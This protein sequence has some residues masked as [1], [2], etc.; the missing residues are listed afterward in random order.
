MKKLTVACLMLCT[1][2]G[3]VFTGCKK[4]DNSDNSGVEMV[5]MNTE[6]EKEEE[7]VIETEKKEPAKSLKGRNLL[8]GEPMEEDK[9]KL[10]P[11]AVMLGNTVD[12]LPQYGIGQA[13]VLYEVPVEGGLTRL[14]AIFQD[15]TNLE[16]VGSVRSCR[17]YFAYYAMEFDAIY[18]HFGQAPY[19]EP[20]LNSGKVSN[21]SGLEGNT[22][23]LAF[24]RDSSRKQP[25]NSF[26]TGKGVVDAIADKGYETDYKDGYA[27]HYV[28]AADGE[29]VELADGMDAK[30]VKPGFSISNP[31]F[32]YNEEDG[33]YYRYQY[34]KEHID[35]ADNSQLA[36]KNIIFQYSSYGKAVSAQGVVDKNGYLD[37]TTTGEGK[38]M[39]IT[40]G[41]AIEITWKK[42]DENS[43]ARYYDANGNEITMN[44]GKTSVSIVLNDAVK[45]VGVY[46]SEAEYEEAKAAN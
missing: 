39:Y 7:E 40:N 11:L 24:Y 22:Y 19:A 13:D 12:A 10:R 36:F 35:G 6:F 4:E 44:Q 20:L 26:A 37:I 31:W 23:N 8:T 17:H 27:G 18:M 5:E 29:N 14:M 21:L 45:R 34:K 25:H 15:Y 9:A 28:F 41:K 1:C 16:A 2:L 38:G 46:A 43:P 33:L 30:V 3:L 32:V 42:T